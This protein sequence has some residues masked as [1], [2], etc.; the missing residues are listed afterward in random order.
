MYLP[1]SWILR[2][3]RYLLCMYLT[4]HLVLWLRNILYSLPGKLHLQRR[5]G[6]LY[7]SSSRLLRGRFYLLSLHST[8]YPMFRN[9]YHLRRL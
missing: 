3:R 7:M 1:N 9:G 6:H 8:M 4:L 2:G 5:S